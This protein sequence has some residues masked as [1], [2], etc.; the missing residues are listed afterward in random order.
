M[1]ARAAAFALLGAC[2]GAPAPSDAP[3]PVSPEARKA[4]EAAAEALPVPAAPPA[5][6]PRAD[7]GVQAGPVP[8]VFVWEGVGALHQGFFQS[9]EPLS[10]LGA[11]LAGWLNGTANIHVH[12]D[13]AA[14]RG[15]IRLRLLPGSLPRPVG[16]SGD[17]VALQDLAPL[18][19]ALAAWRS[20]VAARTD[21][22]LESFAVELESVRGTDACVLGLV[23][24][25]P[26]DGR[27]LS[28]CVEITGTLVCGAPE[29]A[30][31]R[32]PPAAAAALR[33]CL[34]PD[35]HP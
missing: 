9:P 28:P 26:P 21:Y 32:F 27:T 19:T 23:G 11:D 33:R 4:A 6:P 2:A 7:G 12:Y 18:T 30:G 15:R 25:P 34:S 16:G 24:D 1:R 29:A 13:T 17:L 35:A 14:I 20:G 8:V 3:R 5:P 31:V 22:R 10:A